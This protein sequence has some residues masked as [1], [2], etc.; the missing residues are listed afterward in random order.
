MRDEHLNKL[1]YEAR[2][3]IFD[4]HNAL[5]IGWPEEAYHQGLIRLVEARCI[6]YVSKPRL[7]LKHRGVDVD[8]FECDLILWDLLILEL[9]VLPFTSFAPAHLAQIIRYL[10]LWQK[11]FGLLVNF[12][13][14]SAEIK[15]VVWPD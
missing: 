4:T 11:E 1:S 10:K 9:K 5:K 15:R 6:P 7:A 2:G 3:L 14:L 12:G 13:P 8:V